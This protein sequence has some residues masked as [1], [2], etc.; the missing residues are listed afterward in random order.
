[1]NSSFSPKYSLFSLLTYSQLAGLTSVLPR[2]ADV[3]AG[4]RSPLSP[5]YKRNSSGESHEL[6]AESRG[7]L[8]GLVT[9]RDPLAERSRSYE[10][11]LQLAEMKL[12]VGVMVPR[13]R[14]AAGGI[15][16]S[17]DSINSI[18]YFLEVVLNN[19]YLDAQ[20]T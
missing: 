16:S 17:S 20:T 19:P 11:F 8:R 3:L 10:E 5:H 7:I 6:D 12:E 15:F 1:M 14:V 2:P 18:S 9:P 13:W 4:S